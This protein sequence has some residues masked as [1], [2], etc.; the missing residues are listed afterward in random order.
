MLIRNW[1][2][3]HEKNIRKKLKMK[4][5]FGLTKQEIELSNFQQVLLIKIKQQFQYYVVYKKKFY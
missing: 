1:V 5:R 3:L 4:G 2:T